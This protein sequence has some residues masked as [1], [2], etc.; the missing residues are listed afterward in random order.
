MM[1]LH[2]LVVTRLFAPMNWADAAIL[3]VHNDFTENTKLELVIPSPDK[4][5]QNSLI[6]PCAAWAC[7]IEQIHTANL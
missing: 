4:N 1:G 6:T 3:E 7:Q 5:V 2:Q